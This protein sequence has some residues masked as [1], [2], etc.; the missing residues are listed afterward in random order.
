MGT[1]TKTVP[2]EPRGLDYNFSQLAAMVIDECSKKDVLTPAD[3]QQ[4]AF[5]AGV[6][7]DMEGK[8]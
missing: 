4:L 1:H 5:I 3:R 6:M 8:V 7:N 2:F